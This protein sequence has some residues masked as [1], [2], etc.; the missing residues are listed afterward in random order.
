[1]A[2]Q[3]K[4]LATKL[5]NLSLIPRTYM[6]QGGSQPL[7]VA[8]WPPCVCWSMFPRKI[9]WWVT[10]TDL[11]KPYFYAMRIETGRVRRWGMWGPHKTY[12]LLTRYQR[13]LHRV[14]R[15]LL[16]ST[17]PNMILEFTVEGKNKFFQ[18]MLGGIKASVQ[19]LSS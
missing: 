5:N 17:C 8:Q 7:Q 6:V 4:A 3:A 19:H 10:S 16:F 13:R 11:L 18:S 9:T 1:M 14:P 12:L 15:H 2:K